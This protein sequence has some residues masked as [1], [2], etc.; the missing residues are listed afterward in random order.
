MV[1]IKIDTE[2]RKYINEN[3]LKTLTIF[4]GQIPCGCVRPKEVTRVATTAPKEIAE[5]DTYIL[6]RIK[7]FLKRG[8]TIPQ[9]KN[10]I[11]LGTL[12]KERVL[13]PIGIEYF[14]GTGM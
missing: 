9:N 2:A 11:K 7:I 6:E 8:I 3:R 12:G 1:E 13:Y 14:N 10:K 5:F 4:V